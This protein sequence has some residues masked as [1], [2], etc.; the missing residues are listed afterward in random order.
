MSNSVGSK[1]EPGDET[2]RVNT[3][4]HLTG[5]G[6]R[7]SQCGSDEEE[8]RA[9]IGL[10]KK[11]KGVDPD[12]KRVARGLQ[13]AGV[14]AP[15]SARMSDKLHTEKRWREKTSQI[16]LHVLL[17]ELLRVFAFSFLLSHP[18]HNDPRKQRGCAG[19]LSSPF[20]APRKTACRSR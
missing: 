16:Q 10:K 9:E 15:R 14:S 17:G 5:G 18:A 1:K 20:I 11:K 7:S 3:Q 13:A 8:S 2:R 4:T 6:L 12:F 19:F